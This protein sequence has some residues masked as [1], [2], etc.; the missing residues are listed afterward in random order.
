MLY[1]FEPPINMANS[2]VDPYPHCHLSR[3]DWHLLFNSWNATRRNFLPCAC[4]Y[5]WADVSFEWAGVV[6]RASVAEEKNEGEKTKGTRLLF[7]ESIEA[8]WYA[9]AKNVGICALPVCPNIGILGPLQQLA[10]KPWT[11]GGVLLLTCSSRW[12]K[13][14]A[15]QSISRSYT[16]IL[17]FFSSIRASRT[18]AEGGN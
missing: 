12:K 8:S 7:G 2:G 16:S 9:L 3:P 17:L 13:E 5:V 6:P 14:K 15:R 1:K 18:M 11:S 10:Y 4:W